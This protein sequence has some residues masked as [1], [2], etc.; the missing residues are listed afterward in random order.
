M[1]AGGDNWRCL[2]GSEWPAETKRRTPRRRDL[3][4][5]NGTL[6]SCGET[7]Q[8]MLAVSYRCVL[9]VVCVFI[10]AFGQVLSRSAAWLWTCSTSCHASPSVIVLMRCSSC[11][12]EY[13]LDLVPQVRH[14]S[15]SLFRSPNV[16][17]EIL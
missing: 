2:H 16:L 8:E 14:R 5:I 4:F 17:T 15:P 11:A 9:P 12:S 13:T 7:R 3:Q 1:L 6:I 10:F